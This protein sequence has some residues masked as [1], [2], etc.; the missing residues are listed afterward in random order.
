MDVIQ[1]FNQLTASLK[2]SGKK[3]RIA[4][5]CADDAHTEY[6]LSRALEEGIADCV[7]VGDATRLEAYPALKAY[8]DRVEIIHIT[9]ADAAAREAVRLVRQG[10]ADILMKGIINTDNLLHAILDKEHGLLPKG[11]L[12]THLACM[13][14]PAYGKLLLVTDAAVIP[15]PTLQ[16]RE[17][18]IRYAIRV[19]HRFGIL[20]P[21]VALVHCTEK[22]SPKF[23]LS[24]DYAELVE[25]AAAGLF[26]EAIVDGPMDVKTALDRESGLVKGIASTIEGQA[27]V[28]I[29]P[30]IEAGNVF[31][32]TISLF[33]D[34]QMA[35][36]L[37]G[38]DCPVV[39]TSRGDTGLTKYY[40]IAMAC[41]T[42]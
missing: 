27:D 42:A 9:D 8:P 37:Q 40:S 41:L 31:Y 38:P 18:M 36:L 25:Q 11:R 16:Q 30:D 4:V 23:P 2:A 19:C 22:V 21:R 3:K 5:V 17:E 1:N 33:T 24:L 10:K 34:A 32:K 26:G 29:F 15:N 12:L 28:L 20:Q 13:Q 7:L 39:V 6:A 35:G 14:V